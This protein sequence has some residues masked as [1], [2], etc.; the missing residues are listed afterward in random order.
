MYPEF[1]PFGLDVGYGIISN[2]HTQ[3]RVRKSEIISVN[4]GWTAV[5]RR[6]GLNLFPG[7]KPFSILCAFLIHWFLSNKITVHDSYHLV[8][9]WLEKKNEHFQMRSPMKP[10]VVS[11]AESDLDNTTRSKHGQIKS[12]DLWN[13]SVYIM[14]SGKAHEI[15]SI[16]G[17]LIISKLPSVTYG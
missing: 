2:I 17:E 8:W 11:A 14:A 5:E 16:L 13:L 10:A 7:S 1:L 4:G 9:W 3:F 12:F 6:E 15:I